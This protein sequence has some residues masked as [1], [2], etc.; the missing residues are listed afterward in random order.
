MEWNREPIGT[1]DIF[2]TTLLYSALPRLPIARVAMAERRVLPVQHYEA[3]QVADKILSDA[4]AGTEIFFNDDDDA[5]PHYNERRSDKGVHVDGWKAVKR[6]DGSVKVDK[7]W[8][9]Y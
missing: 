6:A 1:H 8:A 5:T 2:Y 3:Q 4:P 7:K 9:T